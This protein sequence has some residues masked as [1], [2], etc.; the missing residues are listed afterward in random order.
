MTYSTEQEEFWAGT[1]GNEYIDR[2]GSDHLLAS[3]IAFFSKALK[4]A[5]KINSVTEFGSNIGMNLQALKRLFP[6]QVQFAIEINNKAVGQLKTFLN[7]DN[8]FH[9]SIFD[10]DRKTVSDLTMTKG[11]LIHL[12]PEMLPLAYKQLYSY[13]SKFILI[14]EYYNPNPVAID[15]RGHEGKLF[16]RDFCAEF[17]KMYPQV[18]LVDYGFAYKKDPAF[19]QD[20]ITWFLMQKDHI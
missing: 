15:Y 10:Y 20:D 4:A 19:S 2:N 17:M 14:C 16:K 3:N 12:N 18:R 6:D 8:I 9:G 1:F 7:A 11:V 5:G 13:S